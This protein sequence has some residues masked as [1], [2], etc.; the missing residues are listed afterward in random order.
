MK[1]I[2]K[3]IEKDKENPTGYQAIKLS[4]TADYFINDVIPPASGA[5]VMIRGEQGNVNSLTES[6]LI[7]GLY[8]TNELVAELGRDT[9][10]KLLIKDIAQV[11]ADNGRVNFF[12]NHG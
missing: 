12:V 3:R 10:F 6:A 11:G 2:S 8:E 1:S 7:K 4:T 5:K 9:G